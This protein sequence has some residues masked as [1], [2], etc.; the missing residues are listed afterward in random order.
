MTEAE[1]REVER[2]LWLGGAEASRARVAAECLMVF[3]APAGLLS[4]DT[5][6]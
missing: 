3:P 5:P 1:F 4:Q 2:A 6:A